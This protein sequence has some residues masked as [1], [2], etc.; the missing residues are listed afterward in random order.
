MIV[1]EPKKQGKTVSWVS[2]VGARPQFIKLAPVCRA[3]EAHNR[4][5][6]WEHILHTIVHTGQ[7][8]DPEVADLLFAQLKIPEPGHNLGAGS[9]SHAVQLAR[10]MERLEPVLESHRP[11]WV[12]VYGDTNSTLAGALVAARSNF[13]LAHIEAG[14]RS[15][16]MA[17]PEEQTRI[18]ADHLSQ[19]LFAP[20][21]TTV[22]NLCREGIGGPS[23][24]QKRRVIFSGDVMLDALTDSISIVAGREQENLDK[25]GLKSR[26][27]YLLTVHRAENTNNAERLGSILRTAEMLDLPV[28]FPVHPRTKNALAAAGISLNGNLRPVAPLGY[29]EM[30]TI[31]KH[32]LKILTD[33]GGVQKEAFYLGTPCVTL[34]NQ[35]EWPETVEVGA[36]CIAGTAPE[37]ILAAVRTK[38]ANSWSAADPYG[39]G[40]VAPKIVSGLLGG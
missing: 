38:A 9:G 30:L 33:S 2:V 40:D 8:Y 26:E 21:K 29:L 10:M 28:L 39:G 32:A 36:N 25:L 5:A 18:V 31:E 14:C 6:G 3:I 7:H 1:S 11:D 24:R 4:E 34:L 17:A 19:L 13:P 37:S 20:S 22:E 27:Y 16:D 23:D 15:F 12:I 35:T